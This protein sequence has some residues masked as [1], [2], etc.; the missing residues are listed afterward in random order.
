[1]RKIFLLASGARR[2]DVGQIGATTMPFGSRLVPLRD[3]RTVEAGRRSRTGRRCRR[4]RGC[5][6]VRSRRRR[7]VEVPDG[8]RLRARRVVRPARRR[9]GVVA[10]AG[11]QLL[12]VL[13]PH[14][15]ERPRAHRIRTAHSPRRCY[16]AWQRRCPRWLRRR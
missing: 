2:L 7:V 3:L 5:A 15:R 6:R 1:V 4:A 13:A 8:G 10:E 16:S 11:A 9:V 14:R 12:D